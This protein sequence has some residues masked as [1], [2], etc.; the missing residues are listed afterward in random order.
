[1]FNNHPTNPGN[2]EELPSTARR[3]RVVLRQFRV[4]LGMR[5][6]VGNYLGGNSYS[7][8]RTTRELPSGGLGWSG[9]ESDH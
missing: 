5:L 6:V 2:H 4:M 3:S 1:M 8:P 7:S 9:Y